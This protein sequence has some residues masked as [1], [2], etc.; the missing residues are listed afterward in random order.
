M[1]LRKYKKMLMSYGVDR[2]Q[3]EADR[4]LLA[5][6][7]RCA[8]RDGCD[9]VSIMLTRGY[10]EDAVSFRRKTGTTSRRGCIKHMKQLMKNIVAV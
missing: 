4:K 2:D 8:L 5:R 10:I 1:T 3:A 9:P 7:K 6:L